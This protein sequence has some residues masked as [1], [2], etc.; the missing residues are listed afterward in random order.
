MNLNV[1]HALKEGVEQFIIATIA[2]FLAM[3]FTQWA[4][5]YRWELV[6]IEQAEQEGGQP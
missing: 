3:K 1:K 5:G 2:V 4:T 6:P